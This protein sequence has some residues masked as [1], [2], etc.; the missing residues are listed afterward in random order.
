MSFSLLFRNQNIT[1]YILSQYIRK[2]NISR[3]VAVKK[4]RDEFVTMVSS[5]A[6]PKVIDRLYVWG[7]AGVGALG[8]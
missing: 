2:Q 1:R 8:T 5:S 3:K 7:Y 6:R 4:E